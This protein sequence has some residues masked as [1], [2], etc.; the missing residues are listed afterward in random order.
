MPPTHRTRSCLALAA[1]IA[2]TGSDRVS[3]AEQPNWTV[4]YAEGMKRARLEMKPV[5]LEFWASWC[6]PCRAMAAEVYTDDRVRRLLD[7]FVLIGVDFD[8]EKSLS[9]CSSAP[10]SCSRSRRS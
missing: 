3:A 7:E 4:N 1:V 8:T 9:T 10:S 2:V 5:C 6:A